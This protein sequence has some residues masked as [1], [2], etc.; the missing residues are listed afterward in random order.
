MIIFPNFAAPEISIERIKHI[1][2]WMDSNLS[3]E[4]QL[5][6]IDEGPIHSFLDK[7]LKQIGM[8][9][10]KYR[11]YRTQLL[12]LGI[13]F[14]IS[15]VLPLKMILYLLNYQSQTTSIIH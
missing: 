1:S 5:E 9:M 6:A 15:N 12:N 2:T 3:L 8:K 10:M 11:N 14:N 13:V 4:Q 7:L